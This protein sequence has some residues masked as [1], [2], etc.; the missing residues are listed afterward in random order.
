V[1][2]E[3]TLQAVADMTGGAYFR[4]ENAQQL[5][6]IFHDLPTQIILQK[7]S[8]EISVLFLALGAIVATIAAILSLKWNRFP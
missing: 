7:E 5:Q 1:I 8:T 3:P 2:D 6:E 4:A